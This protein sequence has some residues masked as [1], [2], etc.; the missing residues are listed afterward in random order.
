M[1]L[2]TEHD[3]KFCSD[4]KRF[5]LTVLSMLAVTVTGWATSGTYYNNITITTPPM[6]D[7]TN[8]VNEGRIQ[9]STSLPFEFSNVQNFTNRSLLRNGYLDG[10]LVVGGLFSG[11]SGFR[12]DTAPVDELAGWNRHPAVNFYNAPLVGNVATNATIYG[13]Y[14]ILVQATN[15]V[16]R[17]AIKVSEFGLVSLAGKTVDTSRGVLATA[18][19]GLRSPTIAEGIYDNYWFFGTNTIVPSQ[20]FTLNFP[21]TTLYTVIAFPPP[22]FTNIISLNLSPLG[23]NSL[24]AREFITE[25]GSNRTVQIVFV[26]TSNPNLNCRVVSAGG[27][28]DELGMPIIEWSAYRTNLSGVV[29]S[30]LLYLSDTYGAI[31]TNRYITNYPYAPPPPANAAVPP[32]SF[33]PV[34][35]TV[36][37]TAP[38]L[39]DFANPGTNFTDKLPAFWGNPVTVTGAVYSAYGVTVKTTPTTSDDAETVRGAGGRV[40]VKATGNLDATLAQMDALTYLKI[41][42]TNHFSGASNAF[43]AAPFSDIALCSTNG[44]LNMSSVLQP[45]VSR[46]SGTLD[47]Y[48]V[49]WTNNVV[50]FG[51]TNPVVF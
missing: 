9:I 29:Q 27:T 38:L 4:M 48:S 5:C 35:F 37:R 26:R 40:E 3:K 20:Q 44:Y 23:T 21:F 18:G 2:L 10:F 45:V 22:Y 32:R 11:T 30:N 51:S 46:I 39:M 47:I 49:L 28:A 36:S 12:F 13:D 8:F 1:N 43:I 6:V 33:Q 34:N 41:D 31:P 15:I 25:Q 19:F 42:S 50:F 17:G 16:N 14:Q 7:A 24:T